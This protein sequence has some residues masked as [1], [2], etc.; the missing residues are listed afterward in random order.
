MYDWPQLQAA[1]DALW[2][3]VAERL[4]RAGLEAVPE[5]LRRDGPLD[6]LWTSPTLLLAQTCGY[7]LSKA[8]AGRVQL[9]ATP[10]YRAPGC[11]GPFRRSAILVRNGGPKLRLDQLIETGSHLASAEAIASGAADV[12]A[13]DAVTYAHLLRFHPR[14][15]A[16]L[17]LMQWTARSP[18]LPLITAAT[19][20]AATLR[21]LRGA[22][23]FAATEP[24][25]AEARRTLMLE[26]FSH[27]PLS[28]YRLI[29]YLEERAAA[30]G[31]PQLR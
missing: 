3:V 22:L 29:P 9:V 14:T 10:R 6:A 16:R 28:H 20:D 27:L 18:G 11:E 8:L 19:T 25:L 30:L 4:R 12:A 17:R 2:S 26:G 1:N 15:A 21:T 13:L 23:A 31:Y 24:R 5:T 7:P